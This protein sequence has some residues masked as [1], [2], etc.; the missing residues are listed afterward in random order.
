ME[1]PEPVE[2]VV[3]P[4]ENPE[5][6]PMENPM[7]NPMETPYRRHKSPQKSE[8]NRSPPRKQTICSLTRGA[9]KQ[10]CG[11]YAQFWLFEILFLELQKKNRD[12]IGSI[13][14][15]ADRSK[16]LR[17]RFSA[18]DPPVRCSMLTTHA[19]HSFKSKPTRLYCSS[20]LLWHGR[21]PFLTAVYACIC[22]CAAVFAKQ[23]SHTVFPF[24]Y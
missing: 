4:M 2:K 21:A 1:N 7:E 10:N 12:L 19:R 6:I 23:S 11:L 14:S 20:S 18:I 22:L 8:P 16:I 24:S 5:P 9:K 17:C 3:C 13:G 15:S